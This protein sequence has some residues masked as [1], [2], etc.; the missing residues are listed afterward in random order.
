MLIGT[1]NIDEKFKAVCP[2]LTKDERKDLAASIKKDGCREAILT[3][4]GYVVDGHNRF[5]IC[6]ELHK[7]YV[8]REVEG[9]KSRA[10][11]VAWIIRNQFARRNLND[12]QRTILALKLKE[13]IAAEA[14]QRQQKAGREKRPQKLGEAKNLETNAKV[15]KL[16]GVS[17]ETVRKVE[18][19]EKDAGPKVKEAMRSGDISINAAYKTIAP[20]TAPE[21]QDGFAIV[22][23][24]DA[25]E[26]E[27]HVAWEACC[28]F[29]RFTSKRGIIRDLRF[30]ALKLKSAAADD[31]HNEVLASLLSDYERRFHIKFRL[32]KTEG[33]KA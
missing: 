7:P 15:A 23:D 9:L 3:W 24:V 17:A 20:K 6:Q 22:A 12:A 31:E 33:A 4:H 11:V 16:A 10:E 18:K 19:V 5:E 28:R 13:T 1:A 8:T 21:P 30:F 2:P 32:Q 14:K 25:P 26:D 27:E 29:P